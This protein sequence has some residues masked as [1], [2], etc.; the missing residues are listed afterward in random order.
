MGDRTNQ[1]KPLDEAT[2]RKLAEEIKTSDAKGKGFGVNAVDGALLG[3]VPLDE[4]KT[5]TNVISKF[6][7]VY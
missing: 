2:A 4:E 3:A 1:E 7:R 5:K 6:K